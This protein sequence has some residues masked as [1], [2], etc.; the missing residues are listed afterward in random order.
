M[1]AAAAGPVRAFI[2]IALNPDLLAALKNVQHQLQA[3]LPSVPVRWAHPEQ[4]HLTLKFLG[5]VPR[6]RLAD[7]AAALNRASTGIAPFQ[8]AL[9]GVGCFPHP[10]NPR[11]VWIG[12]NG[13]LPSLR[14]LQIQ[15]DEQTQGIGD[16]SE[17]RVFQP[18]LTLGRVNAPGQQARELGELVQ[19]ASFP[20]LGR[21]T[22]REIHLIQSVL[23]PDGARYST[24]AT[25]AL[26]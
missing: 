22:V 8:L 5:H 23:S 24:L 25:A 19:T 18:H 14:R 1:V 9:E 7:S 26:R 15:I 11:V 13:E 3:R 2:A 17:E 10:K 20:D 12:I 6:E 16:H 21:W 4:L